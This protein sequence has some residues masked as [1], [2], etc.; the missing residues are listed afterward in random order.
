MSFP[1]KTQ[2]I[3]STFIQVHKAG[4]AVRVPIEKVSHFV[5]EDKY[6]TAYTDQGELL[7][8]TSL[9]KLEAIYGT[10]VAL[11]HRK[12]LVFRDR[13]AKVERPPRHSG[14]YAILSDGREV[15]TSFRGAH[16]YL[17]SL[18]G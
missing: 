10:K 2:H 18:A 12:L 14:G 13:I 7:L 9:R 17:N 4:K 11:L 6:I 8:V 15:A 5:S 1:P 3:L 16:A